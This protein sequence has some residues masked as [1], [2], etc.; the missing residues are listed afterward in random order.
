M[1]YVPHTGA[2]AA[3]H[4]SP[5]LSAHRGVAE[6]GGGPPQLDL[7]EAVRTFREHG[8]VVIRGLYSPEQV[9]KLSAAYDVLLEKAQEALR[10]YNA[11]KDRQP[12]VPTIRNDGTPNFHIDHGGVRYDYQVRRGVTVEQAQADPSLETTLE[13]L[14]GAHCGAAHPDLE[15]I[16]GGDNPVSARVRAHAAFNSACVH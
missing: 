8:C 11:S 9:A 6:V 1:T 3:R 5:S 12:L 14:L 15:A 10:E 2:Y 7:D 4:L 13:L 16:G